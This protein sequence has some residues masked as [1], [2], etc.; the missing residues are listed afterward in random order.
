VDAD[1]SDR[2]PRDPTGPSSISEGEL[3]ERFS[4]RLRFFASRRLGNV[5]IAE[6][7]AQETLRRV[8]I[9]MRERRIVDI[10][11]LPGFVFE[12]ARH[13]CLQ[14][15]RTAGREERALEKLRVAEPD[16]K[17][18]DALVALVSEE[19]RAAVRRALA[20]LDDADRELLRLAFW[21]QLATEALARH[22]VTTPGAVRVRK[23][24]ALRRFAA[25]LAR[26][27]IGN[28]FDDAAT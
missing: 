25:Q 2:A 15:Q 6:D 17:P 21:Q 28:D 13:I 27:G 12:T 20:V 4:M 22:F 18:P 3:A 1:R 7:V 14:L 9:A 23:H 11:A 5:T 8:M 19:R 10:A 26:S 16:A 24:R